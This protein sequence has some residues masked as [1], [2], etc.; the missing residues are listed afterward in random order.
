[1]TVRALLAADSTEYSALWRLALTEHA[2]FF[3]ISIEDEPRPRIPTKF[4]D[5][6]FTLGA[7]QNSRLVGTLS[8]DRETRTKL[9]HKALLSRMFVHPSAAGQGVGTTL[10]KEALI[11]ARTVVG[12]RQL[13]LTVLATNERA[14]GLYASAGFEIFAHEAGSVKSGAHYIDELQMVHFL[15]TGHAPSGLGA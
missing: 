8:L 2:A 1:M 13:V 10:V 7:F 14:I 4:T 12:L 9:R 15:E 5:E 3:R 6:S 11:R